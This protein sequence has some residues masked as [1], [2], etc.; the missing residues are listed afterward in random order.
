M[1]TKGALAKGLAVVVFV[2]CAPAWAGAQARS[3]FAAVTGKV[4]DEQK[5]VLPGVTVQAVNADT[6]LNREAVSEA[7]GTFRLLALPPGPYVVRAALTGFGRSESRLTL[8][9]GQEAQLNIVL[10]VAAIQ[11]TITVTGEAPLVETGKASIGTTLIEAQVR[12]L[13]LQSRNFSELAL[14]T[15]GASG[16]AG[17]STVAFS[18]QR[19][20]MNS[21]KVDGFDNQAQT[22][23]QPDRNNVSQEAIQEL[24]AMSNSY[25]PE[26]GNSAGGVITAITKSGTNM[27]KGS[28]FGF[29]R[30]DSFDKPNY[31]QRNVAIAPFFQARYGATLGGP[32]RKDKVFF[33]AA[34]EQQSLKKPTDYD[35]EAA[36]AVVFGVPPRGSYESI[37]D[38]G[39]TMGKLDLNLSDTQDFGMRVTYKKDQEDTG[40][41]WR[42]GQT[43]FLGGGGNDD[44]DF[45]VGFR[46]NT[47]L[48]SATLNEVRVGFSRVL[49]NQKFYQTEHPGPLGPRPTVRI[50]GSNFGQGQG[51]ANTTDNIKYYILSDSLSM[52]RNKHAFKIGAELEVN[53]SWEDSRFFWNGIFYFADRAAFNRGEPFRFEKGFITSGEAIPTAGYIEQQ[54][55]FFAQ[56]TWTPSDTLS[57]NYGLRY[58]IEHFPE[59][60]SL[61]NPDYLVHTD[62]NNVAPRVGVGYKVGENT[63]I[64]GSGGL[65][66]GRIADEA[67]LQAKLNRVDRYNWIVLEAA[68]STAL[69]KAKGTN[70][71]VTLADIPAKHRS[72]ETGLAMYPHTPV[73]L[74][75]SV[76]IDHQ[77]TR[78]LAVRASVLYA[79]GMNAVRSEDTNLDLTKKVFIRKGEVIPGA[80]RYEAPYDL[81]WFPSDARISPKWD[82]RF[83]KLTNGRTLY[84]GLV[85]S[86][87]QRLTHGF[88]ASAFYTR[89]STWDDREQWSHDRAASHPES[90]EMEWSKSRTHR[91]H[92]FVVSGI[93]VP[94]FKNL[95]A[96]NWNMSVIGTFQSQN[97]EEVKANI[98]FNNDTKVMDR[99]YD[100]MRTKEFNDGLFRNVDLHVGRNFSVGGRARAEVIVEFFNLFNFVNYQTHRVVG[101]MYTSRRDPVTGNTIL[102]PDVRFGDPSSAYPPFQGQVAFRLTF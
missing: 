74:Q 7:D 70:I 95:L 25:A 28:S 84:K 64:R 16:H 20:E 49:Y 40:A 97:P 26:F 81:Y 46:L 76:G 22:S 17:G 44:R 53:D 15:P 21:I 72:E 52:Y 3:E 79:R 38:T 62:W 31:F 9:V 14:L 80:E 50:G 65:F 57:I 43:G 63:Q 91:P 54:Y 75:G 42:K 88:Q 37:S 47:F 13:P 33:F 83:S 51:K 100:M 23:S 67:A 32:I 89:S 34:H 10:S 59:D 30:D 41:G 98:D 60:I 94:P 90:P 18:G 11:E 69:W 8:T 77:L 101:F 19:A 71:P 5:G 102:T 6:N 27:F 2:F 35:L 86:V 73:S 93:W 29:F 36:L 78:T 92:R 56:D 82:H 66:Y 68:D 61:G 4:V 87:E 96:R 85:L 55:H 39:L 1:M 24:Q 45:S 99:P 48:S 58:D 12:N